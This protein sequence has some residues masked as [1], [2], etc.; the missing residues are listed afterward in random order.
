MS[1]HAKPVELHIGTSEAF[2]GSYEAAT[3]WLN[4]VMFYLTVNEEVYNTDA[5]K[6]AFALSYMTK[7]AILTW[8]TTFWQKALSSTTIPL[9]GSLSN[10]WPRNPGKM[11]DELYWIV[12]TVVC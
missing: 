2:D 11:D 10:K 8:A 5:K 6:I 7:E 3:W 12:G 1:T 9:L 4:S